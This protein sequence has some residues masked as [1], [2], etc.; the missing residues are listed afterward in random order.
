M[1]IGPRTAGLAL[2]LLII[3]VSLTGC[4][5]DPAEGMNINQDAAGCAVAKV[6]CYS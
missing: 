2:L 4:A 6:R 3:A 5:G 1:T